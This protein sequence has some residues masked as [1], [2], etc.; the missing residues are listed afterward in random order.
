MK[1]NKKFL[2]VFLA[3]LLVIM[4]NL[5]YAALIPTEVI[6]NQN[7]TITYNDEIQRFKN[8]N[9]D[10]VYPLSYD[11]TTYL[12]IRS[13]SCLFETGIMWDGST[14]S[15]YLGSGELDTVAA[16]SIPEFVAGTNQNITVS[17]N[18][19]IKIYHSGE[20]QTFKDVNGKVVYPLSY[21]GTTYLPVRA[22]SSLYDANIEWIGETSTV[23]ITENAKKWNGK[24]VSN[25]D[26]YTEVNLT[27]NEV[28]FNFIIKGSKFNVGFAGN[29][30]AI[31]NGNIGIYAK[32]DFET[33]EM[34]DT[35]K[36][37]FVNSKL[38]ITA[39]DGEFKTFEGEYVLDDG[40]MN[41][42][43]LSNPEYISA[44]YKNEDATVKL[45][46]VQLD[47][48]LLDAGFTGSYGE[49]GFFFTGAVM[50][51]ENGSATFEE[52][53]FDYTNKIEMQVSGDTVV[54]EATSTEKD[55]MYQYIGGTYTFVEKKVWDFE[56][57]KQ[58]AQEIYVAED[59]FMY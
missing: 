46:L 51:Y 8:V 7:L 47:E 25:V 29:S 37:E 15:I 36:F 35:L 24:F 27:P 34:I 55:S 41:T 49:D 33:E 14:N 5:V 16:E 59:C 30:N 42:V 39:L 57:C 9:G 52:E 38:V 21:N 4:S 54:V 20:V 6:L 43:V 1:I 50:N 32:E 58:Q 17:L 53:V 3:V 13:I 44:V 23:V 45:E 18:E 26:G 22:I 2:V 28:G 10:V 31:I 48:A 12:P 19:D 11:G 40:S 56:A